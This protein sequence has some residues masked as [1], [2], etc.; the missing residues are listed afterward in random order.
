MNDMTNSKTIPPVTQW[1]SYVYL[2]V[3]CVCT[4]A[5][6]RRVLAPAG[7]TAGTASSHA[8]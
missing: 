4:F 6:R 5:S 7:G 3:L 1:I 2:G 8:S